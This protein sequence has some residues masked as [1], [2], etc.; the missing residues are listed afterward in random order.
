MEEK[1]N[2]KSNIGAIAAAFLVAAILI[3]AFILVKVLTHPRE[4][5]KIIVSNFA[6]Y[7]LVRAVVGQDKAITMLIEPGKNIHDYK[8]TDDDLNAIKSAELFVYF[9]GESE[10]WVDAVINE[11]NVYDEKYLK[12]NNY[13]SLRRLPESTA[14]REEYTYQNNYYQYGTD[15]EYDDHTWLSL[16]NMI[17]ATHIVADRLSM[18]YPEKREE[19]HQRS[20]EYSERLN[21]IDQKFRRFFAMRSEKQPFVFAGGF[22]FQYMFED[23]NIPYYFT[24]Y[25]D[26]EQNESNDEVAVDLIDKAKTIGNHIIFKADLADNG[27]INKIKSDSEI[28]IVELKSAHVISGQDFNNGV[29]FA[30]IMEQNYQ[31]IENI[32]GGSQENR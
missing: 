16:S 25:C 3:G 8:P 31:T 10:S 14:D 32:L 7:D 28:R 1:E 2:L 30:D 13:L 23:Y 29:T 21:D 26:E 18:I 5:S 4:Y 22:P 9:G 20:Q 19:Y 17:S 6:A 15:T 27:V 24:I 11:E 12:L